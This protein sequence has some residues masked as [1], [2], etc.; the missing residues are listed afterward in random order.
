MTHR[1]GTEECPFNHVVGAKCAG[2]K[3]VYPFYCIII[4]VMN[5]VKPKDQCLE[6]Q[7]NPFYCIIWPPLHSFNPIWDNNNND[8]NGNPRSAEF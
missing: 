1:L 7:C 4:N 2:N 8:N 5:F 3:Q 6:E